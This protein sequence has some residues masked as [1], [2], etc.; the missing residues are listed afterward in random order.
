MGFNE[1]KQMAEAQQDY[2]IRIRRHFHSFPEVS[3]QEFETSNFIAE[4]LDRMGVPYE[5]IDGTDVRANDCGRICYNES[6]RGPVSRPS[7]IF[8]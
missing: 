1:I 7:G 6:L 5:R 8:N 4:E 2:M 3:N